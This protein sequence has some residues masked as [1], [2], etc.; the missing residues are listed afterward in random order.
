MPRIV[1][2]AQMGLEL[3]KIIFFLYGSKEETL[4]VNN[5]TMT[6]DEIFDNFVDKPILL[7]V[8]S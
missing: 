3:D 4:T 2:K 6:R 1:E 8:T 5:I 7:G